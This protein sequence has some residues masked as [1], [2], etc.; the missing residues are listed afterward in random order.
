MGK[1]KHEEIEIRIRKDGIPHKF[2]RCR[3]CKVAFEGSCTTKKGELFIHKAGKK[4]YDIY[5]KKGEIVYRP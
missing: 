3:N 2:A 1:C 4:L 5:V